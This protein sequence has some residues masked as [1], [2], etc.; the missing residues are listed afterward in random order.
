MPHGKNASSNNQQ[1]E[2]EKGIAGKDKFR[3]GIHHLSVLTN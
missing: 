2:G 3:V 1:N